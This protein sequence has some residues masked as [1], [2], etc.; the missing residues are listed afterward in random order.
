M[1]Q[2]AFVITALQLPSNTVDVPEVNHVNK[3][4]VTALV[5]FHKGTYVWPEEFT[6]M[7]HQVP[8]G[9]ENHPLYPRV[10]EFE[11]CC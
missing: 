5:D 6:V 1:R 7:A 4:T 3:S 9:D 2:I 11:G 8:V 10:E